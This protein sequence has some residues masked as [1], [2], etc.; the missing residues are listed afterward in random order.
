MKKKKANP[1]KDCR[2]ITMLPMLPIAPLQYAP[3]ILH[4]LLGIGGDLLQIVI[5]TLSLLD[6]KLARHEP[7]RGTPIFLSLITFYVFR[8]GCPGH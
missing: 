3:P 5:R 7:I 4:I 2:S 1:A 8:N 6:N